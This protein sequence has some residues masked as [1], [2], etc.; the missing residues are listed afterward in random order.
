MGKEPGC[1]LV[2]GTNSTHVYSN[3]LTAKANTFSLLLAHLAADAPLYVL[4]D[5]RPDFLGSPKSVGFIR[6]WGIWGILSTN[7]ALAKQ[8]PGNKCFYQCA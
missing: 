2:G 3:S 5:L 7:L 4:H 8:F 1:G 6:T